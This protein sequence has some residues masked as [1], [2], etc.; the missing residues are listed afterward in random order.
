[1][2]IL[3]SLSIALLIILVGCSHIGSTDR[4]KGSG[5]V[6]TEK[7]ALTPFAS[8]E[9]ICH[10][11]IQVNSQ[12]REG[13]EISGD[14]NILPIITT[15]VNNGTLYIRSSKD[16]DPQGELKITV[17]VPDLKRF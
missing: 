8:L 6:K 1:M 14:D 12:G 11:S 16:Y 4:V 3:T 17:S 5:I 10:G 13:L 15:E 9:V 7:R 2:K